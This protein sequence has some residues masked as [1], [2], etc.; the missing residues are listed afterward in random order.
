MTD[1]LSRLK[2]K[3]IVSCQALENE[4]LYGSCIMAKM[5]TAAVAGGAAAI[6]ANTPEDIRE[7]KKAVGV[8]VIGLYKR[9]YEDSEIYI[10]PTLREVEQIVLAGADIVAADLTLRRRPYNHTSDQ[11]I[12]DYKRNFPQ[13]PL[14]ADIATVAESINAVE[15]GADLISTT[16][17]GYTEETKHVKEFNPLILKEIVE[18]TTRPVIA[19]GRIYTPEEAELALE[20]GAYAVVVGSAITRPLVMTERFVAKIQK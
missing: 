12:K 20:M 15:L 10:T 1:L 6:R 11:F 3:L 2:G 4:P 18:K 17:V 9:D 5:A 13:V 7:I 19:E 8:T 16:L 14:M